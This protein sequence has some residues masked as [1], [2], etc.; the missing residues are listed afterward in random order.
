MT[1][2]G[3]QRLKH[4]SCVGCRMLKRW[5]NGQRLEQR[6]AM[7]NEPFS[8]TGCSTVQRLTKCWRRICCGQR[9]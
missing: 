3:C 8:I 9:L 6:R 4:D 1:L 5:G 2:A 7:G